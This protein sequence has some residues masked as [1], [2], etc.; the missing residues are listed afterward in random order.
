MQNIM[1]AIS[2][3]YFGHAVDII[4]P[5]LEFSSKHLYMAIDL[6]WVITWCGEQQLLRL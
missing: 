1:S 2:C 4:Y 6:A 3:S 5:M